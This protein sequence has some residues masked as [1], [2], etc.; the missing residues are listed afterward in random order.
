MNLNGKGMSQEGQ[1]EENPFYGKFKKCLAFPFVLV[2]NL[3]F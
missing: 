1:E 2:L 3:L